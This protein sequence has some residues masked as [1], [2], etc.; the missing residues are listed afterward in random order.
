MMLP[1]EI[2]VRRA[3]SP[4]VE[5]VLLA[6]PTVCTV[7]EEFAPTTELLFARVIFE[8]ATTMLSRPLMNRTVLLVL[9]NELAELLRFEPKLLLARNSAVVLP[10]V[11]AVA[12]PACTM[13]AP[14]A[15]SMM[16]AVFALPLIAVA[17]LT[18][19]LIRMSPETLFKVTER[20]VSDPILRLVFSL[21]VISRAPGMMN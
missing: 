6:P 4:L 14:D 21:R 9:P 19:P 3:I 2:A 7:T 15:P 17:A 13:T 1:E 10:P 20:P 11:A 8:L 16:D 12:P 18:V 5:I